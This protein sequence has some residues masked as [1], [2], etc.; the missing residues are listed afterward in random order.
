MKTFIPSKDA[1][2]EDSISYFQQQLSALGFNIEEASWL[3]PVPNVWSVHIRDKDCPLCFTNGKGA[4]KKAALASALGEY[5]ERLATNY[6]FADFYL[7]QDIARGDFVHYPNEKWFPLTQDNSLPAGLLDDYTRGFYDPDGE[8][9]ADMLIDLQSGNAERGICALPFARQDN[10]QT[11]YIPMNIVGNLYVSNGMSAGNTR[12]EARTQGLSEVFERHIK[13]RI[14]SERISLPTIPAEVMARYPHIQESIAALEAEGFPIHAFDASLG[15]EYPVI[16][17][18]LFNPANGTCFASFG[19]HPRFE[20]ALERTVTELLQGRSLKDLDVFVPP[21]FED[22]EVADHHNLE[23][24]FIDSSGLISWDMFKEQADFEFA[25]WDFSGSSEQE[26]SHLMAIFNKLQ[27]PVY[28]ADYEH[29]GVYAC[30][31]LVPGMSDIYPVEDML[32]ANNNM[33]AHLRATILS[34]P[35]SDA[36]A[37]QLMGFYEQ[38]EEEGLDDFT[39]VRELIGVAPNKGTAWHTLRVGELK[40]M[41][42][43]AAGEL[44]TAL[45]YA[46][47]TLS[48]NA[49]VFTDAR[50]RYY[51]CLKASLE[52]HLDDSRQPEQYRAAFESMYGADTVA[53]AWQQIAGTARFHGLTVADESLKDFAAHQALLATYEKLQKAKRAAKR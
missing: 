19:A 3:N 31:I 25:D 51:R 9:T 30:R 38:L 29:L 41:L 46:D 50:Q 39:R 33:G 12:T 17:V 18:V 5:F 23:T 42:A 26:F 24:H 28:I 53:Q 10:G 20:V 13:N 15:G 27:Q 11:V 1:A 48:F 6:F 37:E 4:S 52:L 43:L 44:E 40:G 47:W 21:S 7:G 32:L 8:L 16:C 49:S 45:D 22:D 14:I 36:D 35:G 34:L 2:L